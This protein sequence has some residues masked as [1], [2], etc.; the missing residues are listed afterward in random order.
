[1]IPAVHR[2]S[3]FPVDD[4]IAASSAVESARKSS[5]FSRY[6]SSGCPV[7][8]KPR[9]SFSLARR[10]GSSPPGG[11]GRGGFPRPPSFRLGTPKTPASA[12]S[13]LPRGLLA[14]GHAF[15]RHAL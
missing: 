6:L 13:A 7:I 12:G 10:G 9:I 8:K 3:S 5:S 2:F 4:F 15:L 11:L 1:M 14:R